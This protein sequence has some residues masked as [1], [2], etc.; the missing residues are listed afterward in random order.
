MISHW[1][2]YP[3]TAWVTW[4]PHQPWEDQVIYMESWLDLRVGAD[5]WAW[6]RFTLAQAF[7]CGV[8]FVRPQDQVRF[9]LEWSGGVE[10]PTLV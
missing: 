5:A 6:Q 7:Y 3:Y 1:T 2:Q 4:H 10:I 9:L 8:V